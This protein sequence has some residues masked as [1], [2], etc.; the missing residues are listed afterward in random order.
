LIIDYY[1]RSVWEFS[2]PFY[3]HASRVP[4]GAGGFNKETKE[5][6]KMMAHDLLLEIGTEEIPAR[7]VLGALESLRRLA[8]ERLQQARLPYREIKTVGTPRRLALLAFSLEPVQTDQDEIVTGPPRSAAFGEDGQPTKVALGFARAKGVTVDELSLLETPKGVYLGLKKKISGRSAAALLPELLP[9]LILD[10][11]FPKNMRWGSSNLRFARPIHW[12][13]ALYGAEEIPFTLEG[14]ASGRRTFGHRF[15]APGPLSLAQAGDYPERLLSAKVVVDPQERRSIL[16]RELEVQARRAGGQVLIDQQLLEEVTNLV[17]WPVPVTGQ[18][19][20]DFLTLP[21]EVLKTSMKEHQRYFPLVNEEEL[22]INRFIAVNNT[23]VTDEQRVI[24]GHEKVLRA[25][26]SDARFFY[27]EDTKEPLEGKVERLR[28]VVFH[29][30]LGT[31]YEKMERVTELAAYLA[32]LLVPEKEALV[33]RCARLAKADLTSHMVGEFP[34]L[35][36]VMGREYAR[37]SGEDPEVAQGIFEH[38][39]PLSAQDPPPGSDTGALVGLAD[40]L[41]TLAGFFSLNQIPTGS[42]DPYA[43]RRQAQGVILITWAKDYGFSLEKALDQALSQYRGLSALEPDRIK[44][45]LLEFFSLRL[46]YLLTSAGHKKEVLEAVLAAGWSD[47]NEVRLRTQALSQFQNNIEFASLTI[48][49]KR[50]LN[51]LKGIDLSTIG[52]IREELFQEEAEIQLYEKINE[53]KNKLNHLLENKLYSLYLQDIAKL[54]QYIDL[55]FEQVL[56]MAP[57]QKIKNNRLALL[58]ELTSLFN[59]FALFSLM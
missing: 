3:F 34:S 12:I 17:E 4:C 28:G 41:D 14:I 43:L 53:N 45:N 29:S 38:Y 44:G 31:S 24:R 26:L 42:A 5:E 32:R 48:G 22:L 58:L 23:Q 47:L 8:E 13:V 46:E 56:V 19:D 10:L 30:H 37:L 2:R 35:Q 11:S 21:P 20:P 40:R 50:A 55:F 33:K 27:R 7:F 52:S 51:I 39:L 36:G 9:Q 15:M 16:T 59:R 49:C 6:E 57:D 1:Y 54:R 25:R 18:F